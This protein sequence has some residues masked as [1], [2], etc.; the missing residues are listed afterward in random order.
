MTDKPSPDEKEAEDRFN[1]T[2]GRLVN[3]PHTPHK[4]KRGSGEPN[5]R[6]VS[7]PEKG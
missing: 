5:P 7:V 4:E 1:E 2:L 3:T 6:P